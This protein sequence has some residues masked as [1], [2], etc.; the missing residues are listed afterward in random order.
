M[1]NR[2]AVAAIIVEKPDSVTPLNELLHEY[3]QYIIGR[4]G[5][6]YRERSISIISLAMD[7][8]QDI[9]NAMTGKIGRLK[10]VTV[11]TAYSSL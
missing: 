2:V 1:E 10:G 7:A 11:K 3:R 6:P 8:P 4:M 5:I 9:I